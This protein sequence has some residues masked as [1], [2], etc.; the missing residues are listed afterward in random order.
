MLWNEPNNLSHWNFEIDPEWSTFAA[1][2]GAKVPDFVAGRSFL[3]LLGK[4]SPDW[5]RTAFMIVCRG[6]RALL[7]GRRAGA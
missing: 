6:G 2:V 7:A 4:T 1:M 3:P 5:K